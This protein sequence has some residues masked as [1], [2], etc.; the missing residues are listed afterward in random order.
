MKSTVL[1]KHGCNR[2]AAF[3]ESGFDNGTFCHS[4]GVCFKFANFCNKGDHFEKSVDV[5]TGF[6]GNGNT[7]YVAAPFFGDK[8][9]F[10]KTLH[11]FIGV[12]GGFIDFVD[13]YDNGNFC[14]F[15][16]VDCFNSLGHDTVVC[17]NNKDSNI[18]AKCATGT[19]CG[20]CFVSGSIEEGDG[21][22]AFGGN[23][24]CT[25]VLGDTA[26]FAGSN[27]CASDIVEDGSLTVVN[28]AH[29]ADNRITGDKVCCIVLA[30]VDKTVFDGYNNFFFNFCADIHCDKC[31]GIVV[32]NFVYGNHHA[33]K[34]KAFD[35]FGRSDF[36]FKSKVANGDFIRNGDFKFLAALTF[37]FELFEFFLLHLVFALLGFALLFALLVEFLLVGVAVAHGRSRCDLFIFIVIF[38]KIDG[39]SA[40]IN[41]SNACCKFFCRRLV[42]GA[43]F[44]FN[45]FFGFVA[46]A[47]ILFVFI[48]AKASAAETVVFIEVRFVT[49]TVIFLET[50][51]IAEFSFALGFVTEFAVA[52]RSVTLGSVAEF[53]VAL[54]SVTL[55][56]VA[57]FTIALGSVTLRSVTEFAIAL[58]SVPLRSVTEFAVALRSVALGSVAEFA[59]TLRSVTLGSFGTLV[60][61]SVVLTVIAV[62]AV[63][64]RFAFCGFL[65]GF[66]NRFF[67][68]FRSGFCFGFLFF[69]YSRFFCFGSGFCFSFGCFCFGLFFF[70]FGFG[71]ACHCEI[72]SETGYFVLFGVMFKNVVKFLFGKGSL[73]L[74]CGE[75]FAENVKNVFNRFFKVFCEIRRFIF[76]IFNHLCDSSKLV[77][78]FCMPLSSSSFIFF[79]K[80]LSQTETTPTRFATAYPISSMVRGKI[81]TSAPFSSAILLMFLAV[82]SAQSLERSTAL[83]VPFWMDSTVMSKP[84]TSFPAFLARPR[85]PE[86]F[87]FAIG[88]QLLFKRVINFFRNRGFEN[89]FDTFCFARLFKAFRIRA[90]ISASSGASA[91]FIKRNHAFRAFYNADKFALRLFLAAAGAHSFGNFFHKKAS[92]FRK[93]LWFLMLIILLHP[94]SRFRV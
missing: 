69:F 10:G 45:R 20:E 55:G 43:G 54:R 76:N 7:D 5:F 81:K 53:A 41:V 58:R 17:C 32:D 75:F 88:F 38:V 77:H 2:A 35:D 63:F 94:K 72:R 49:E 89:S 82:L 14:C 29:Y 15:C 6:C 12:C 36:K 90:D 19:H 31:C 73:C 74:F 57:E 92:S 93:S 65:F 1:N 68:C 59:I 4:V 34:H 78:A 11:N 46:V 71:L 86:S 80:P 22:S 21:A 33:L 13:S 44:S 47:V 62:V 66:L 28:V 18:G 56:S 70:R 3:I 87:S 61:S 60:V 50:G 39:N 85:K 40:H 42:C 26:C 79:E 30:V 83:A 84:K 51:F 91:G 48:K 37:D 52:L 67:L 64:E 16:V 23:S 27:M 24:V 8:A 9:V 25:E